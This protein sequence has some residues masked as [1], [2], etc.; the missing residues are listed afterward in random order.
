MLVSVWSDNR[1]SCEV[2]DVLELDNQSINQSI[3]SKVH[4]ALYIVKVNHDSDNII[5][6]VHVLNTQI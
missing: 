2:T 3:K 1:L 6:N 4:T 5:A